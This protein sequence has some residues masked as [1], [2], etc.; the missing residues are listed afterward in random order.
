LLSNLHAATR[1]LVGAYGFGV[2]DLNEAVPGGAPAPGAMAAAPKAAD[3]GGSTPAYSGT[4]TAEPG[5]DEPDLVKTDGH[6]IVTVT[7]TTLHVVDAR[8]RAVTGTLELSGYGQPQSLLLAG[9]RALVLFPWGGTGEIAG[10]RV[11]LVDLVPATPTVL[12]GYVT[13]GSLVDARQVGTVAR[14]VV[15]SGPRIRYPLDL[16]AD[17]AGRVAANQA[18]VDRTGVDDWLP[19]YSVTGR[20]GTQTG[21]VECGAVRLPTRYSGTSLLSVLTFDLSKPAL[22]DGDPVTIA[23]DGQTVYANGTSLYVVNGNQWMAW[24]QAGFRGPARPFPHQSEVYQFDI[25]GTGTPRYVAGGVV[26][27]WV[28]NQYALSEWQDHLRVATTLDTGSS[29]VAVLGRAGGALTQVGVVGGLGKG[30]RI[31]GV[32]F[33]GPV[34]YVVTFRQ[35]DPLYTLDLRDPA[36][37][38][39][40]GEL[41]IDGYSAYLHPAGDGRLIGVG[42]AANSQGRVQG[43]QVSLFDVGDPARPSLLARYQLAGSGHSIAEF[44]PHAFLYWAQTG[45]VV[46]PVQGGAVALKAGDRSLQESGRLPAPQGQP[47]LRALVVGTTLWSVTGAGLAAADLSSLAPQAWLAF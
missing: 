20:N 22:S 2:T 26:P 23:A 39:V 6:R 40:T 16:G 10:P 32:R 37:P 19:R 27:G 31:Y 5:A 7:G 21:R 35:T 46:V 42:Q 14:V 12:S 44:D 38:R 1:P 30:Q 45:L 3:A 8:T 43:L 41:E 15:R 34:G 36:R 25:S 17:P 11:L 9:D 33:A 28:V 13:D 4:N 18:A 29:Q 47:L 24:P